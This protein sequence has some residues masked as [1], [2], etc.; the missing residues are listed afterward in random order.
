[1]EVE[2][3]ALESA[4]REAEEI[5]A[6]ADRLL[7]PAWIERAIGREKQSVAS[8]RDSSGTRSTLSRGSDSGESTR[9]QSPDGS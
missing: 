7:V 8:A 1:M 9:G 6:I 4:W 5:A 3:E 2:L